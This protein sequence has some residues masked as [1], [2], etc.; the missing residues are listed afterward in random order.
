M[1]V[2]ELARAIAPECELK[3][4]GIR[5]GEKLHEL[6]IPEDDARCTLEYDDHYRILPQFHDWDSDDYY[7]SNGGTWCPDGFSYSSD[8]ND[9]WL[10][11]DELRRMAGLD[12]GQPQPS[13]AGA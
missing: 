4:I 10:T 8:S 6:M 9:H 1:R 7:R 12:A 5:P 3:V 2:T 13:L 11:P